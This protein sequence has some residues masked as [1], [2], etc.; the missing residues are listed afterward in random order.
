MKQ[1]LLITTF[2]TIGIVL[3]INFLSS[4]INFRLDFTD[5]RQ[6]TLS[7]ATLDILKSLEEP[8][9]IKA[10]FSRDLPANVAKTRQDFQD[11]LIEYANR[12]DGMIAYEFINPN[13]SE[14]TEQLAMQNGVQQVMINI[15]EK[16]QV[17]QQKAFL[18]ATLSLGGKR[19]VIP[20]VQPG[21]AMEYALSTSLKKLS[22]DRKPVVGFIQG[23]GEP[24]VG[25]MGQAREQLAVRY[26]VQELK[27]DSVEIPSAIRTVVLIRPTDSIPFLHLQRIDVFLAR[28][29]RLLIAMNRVQGNLQQSFGSAINTGLETWLARKG[30]IVAD[31]FIVDAKCGAVNVQ[32]QQG[33]FT[34]QHQVSFPFLPAIAKFAN[35]PVSK[36]L[37]TVFLE[38]ASPVNYIG[39]TTKRF[40]PL[41]F[42]SA[43]SGSM[44]APLR[45]DI[46]KKW[47]EADF[48]QPNIPVAGI[49]EGKLSGN[50]RTR[51]VVIG[52]G[53]LVVNGAGQQPRR[54]Q[55]DN[56]SLVVNSIDWLSDD[57]GLIELRTKGVTSRPI[58]EL[59]DTTK[60][61]L[62]YGNFSL[63]IL[64]VV[65]YGLIRLQ[66]NRMTRLKRMSE[67]YE[68][69]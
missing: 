52:D 4:E 38:F 17:K 64:I 18:G 5:E 55:P 31:A 6:Y 9:T 63:P 23:H 26:D 27:L 51:M 47:S 42:S 66:R 1:K 32:Q 14:S 43:Q 12:S 36:G 19:E 37:E 40:T 57:T 21:T 48:Q 2:L 30:L 49:L 3:V 56:I 68:E 25:E 22:I 10:Y 8:V 69:N 53:D 29:G 13:E 7:K 20:L 67:N 54:L 41:A 33:F 15:R 59:D 11:L 62:K 45:F 58:Y 24:P 61:I 28:G 34:M 60:S 44:S 50:A 39:D 46:G 65:V 35:H 16:D